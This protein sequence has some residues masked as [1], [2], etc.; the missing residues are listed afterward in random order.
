MV[1]DYS[2]HVTVLGILYICTFTYS[3]YLYI[4]CLRVYAL[5][6]E[7]RMNS[8]FSAFLAVYTILTLYTSIFYNIYLAADLIII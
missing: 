6:E 7:E 4:H 2:W 8:V 5:L 3:I 1:R